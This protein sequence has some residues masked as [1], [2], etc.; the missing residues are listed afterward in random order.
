MRPRRYVVATQ[1][2]RVHR[3]QHFAPKPS[4]TR[5]DVR[6]GPSHFLSGFNAQQINR[7]PR[8]RS[9]EAVVSAAKRAGQVAATES[10]R[11]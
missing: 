11:L 9:W 8:H 7:R 5:D 1:K 2:L 4:A 10:D 6:N 3:E